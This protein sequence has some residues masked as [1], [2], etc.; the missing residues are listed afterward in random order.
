MLIY[1][2]K[3][4]TR[5]VIKRKLTMLNLGRLDTG[6]SQNM[7]LKLCKGLRF[8]ED[9]NGSALLTGSGSEFP[10][11]CWNKV[12]PFEPQEQPWQALAST[13]TSPHLSHD[14]M[15]VFG[16][17]ERRTQLGVKSPGGLEAWWICMLLKPNR[18]Y[19]SENWQRHFDFS[20]LSTC[21]RD[22]HLGTKP[23]R[24]NRRAVWETREPR[25]S[26]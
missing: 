9:R 19:S 2:G 12:V 20:G 6:T 4:T 7:P 13:L 18:A 14:A 17:L 15:G 10:S 11:G 1:I 21:H 5:K 22:W 16:G 26:D 24:S 23:Q 25:A 8:N 3:T